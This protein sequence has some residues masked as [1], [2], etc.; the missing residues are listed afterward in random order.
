MES[1]LSILHKVI[2]HRQVSCHAALVQTNAN[3]ISILKRQ[4]NVSVNREETKNI[5][6]NLLEMTVHVFF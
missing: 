1:S 2:F 6:I 3:S 4:T 5:H